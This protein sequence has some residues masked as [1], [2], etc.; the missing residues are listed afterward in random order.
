MA[1]EKIRFNRA[2]SS[3]TRMKDKFNQVIVDKAGFPCI[4]RVTEVFARNGIMR[5]KVYHHGIRHNVVKNDDSSYRWE[6]LA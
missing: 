3:I 2:H 6:I 4:C 5:G 1:V